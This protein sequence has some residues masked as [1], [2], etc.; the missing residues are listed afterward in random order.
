MAVLLCVRIS[1]YV[2]MHVCVY[3]QLFMYVATV[4]III[5][6]HESTI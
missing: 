3:V 6:S 2:C 5:N 4:H 1:M